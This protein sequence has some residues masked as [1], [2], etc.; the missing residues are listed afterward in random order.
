MANSFSVPLT[1]SRLIPQHTVQQL[2]PLE[3]FHFLSLALCLQFFQGGSDFLC[4]QGPE[5]LYQL[6]YYLEEGHSQLCLGIPALFSAIS[7]N[8]SPTIHLCL[9]HGLP[10]R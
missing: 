6:G 2:P 8:S 3:N 4:H 10:V 9:P 5:D 7:P 1:W